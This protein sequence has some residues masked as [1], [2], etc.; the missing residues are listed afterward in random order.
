MNIKTIVTHDNCADGLASAM[1]LRLGWPEA[2]VLFMQYN[3]PELAALQPSEGMIFC[4]FSPPAEQAQEF[5]DAGA[6]CLDHHRTAKDV[7]KRFGE[8]GIFADER[9]D[10]GYSGAL[11]AYYFIR[12]YAPDRASSRIEWI[13]SFAEVIGIRDTWQRDHIRWQEACEWTA[14]LMFYPRDMWLEAR[15]DNWHNMSR[16]GPTLLKKREEEI[17]YAIKNSFRTELPGYRLMIFQGVSLTSD[18]AEQMGHDVDLVV[19]FTYKVESGTPKIV[20]SLRSH[21]GFDCAAFAKSHGGGGHSAA[22]GFSALAYYEPFGQ[23]LGMFG[24]GPY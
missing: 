8:R 10:P 13:R 18:V 22:A 3:T 4:D 11:L 17:A 24:S 9:K 2:K 20:Y 14:A 1:I 16:I 7:V 6:W 21:T 15:T 5:I 19:G 12:Q 23:F